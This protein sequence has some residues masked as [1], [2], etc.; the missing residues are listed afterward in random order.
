MIS[1]AEHTEFVK[2]ME[3]ENKRQ[4]NRLDT[5][6]KSVETFREIVSSVNRL[7]DNMK[8]MADELANQ[9]KRIEVI[10]RKPAD[11]WNTIVKSI[12]TNFGATIAALI[13]GALVLSN[14]VK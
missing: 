10:E 5:M 13:V 9:G 12:L 14:V 3:E 7:A 6:E 2:R 4:N 11:N 1:R 8:D